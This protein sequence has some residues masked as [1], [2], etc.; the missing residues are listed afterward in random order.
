[1]LLPETPPP[2]PE[3]EVDPGLMVGLGP[4]TELGLIAGL[5]LLSWVVLL[6]LLVL[7]WLL[8]EWKAMRRAAMVE[9]AML[10]GLARETELLRWLKFVVSLV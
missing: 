3:L 6:M 5:D 1:M 9:E 4:E 7:A 8:V 10:T 2:L